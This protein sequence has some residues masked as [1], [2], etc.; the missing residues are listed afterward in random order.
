MTDQTQVPQGYKLKK[1]KPFF[2]RWWFLLLVLIVLIIV[3]VASSGDSDPKTGSD[4]K[5]GTEVV[6]T[7]ETDAGTINNVTYTTLNGKNIGQ[8]QANGTAAPFSKTM[9]VEDSFFNNYSVTAQAAEGATSITCRITA[10]GK[11][12]SEQT[13]TGQ[14]AVVTCSGS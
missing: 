9:Q 1:K 8:E 14:F 2:F 12:V 5:A 10:D 4:T 3:I 6:Y 13:S 7:V 11:V